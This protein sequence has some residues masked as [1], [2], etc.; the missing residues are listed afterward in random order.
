MLNY[1]EHTS[2]INSTIIVYTEVG[3]GERSVVRDVTVYSS[4]IVLQPRRGDAVHHPTEAPSARRAA[5][6]GTQR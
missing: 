6:E 1:I 2:V 5:G 3:G 4:D